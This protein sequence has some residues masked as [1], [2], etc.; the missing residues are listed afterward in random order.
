MA[1]RAR[2][3]PRRLTSWACRPPIRY[4]MARD[5]CSTRSWPAPSV[6]LHDLP[7]EGGYKMHV[8]VEPLDLTL[9]SPFRIARGT[10]HVA[11][12]VLVEVAYDGL[13]GLGEAA[14]SAFY[15]ERRE[16]VL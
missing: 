7:A 6:P 12:N 11:R 4:A 16:T 5:R 3:S 15:G 10:Q 2:P 9:R 8:D 1:T 14:P 13:V